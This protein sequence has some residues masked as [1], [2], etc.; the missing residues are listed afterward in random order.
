MKVYISGK[1]G[2]AKPSAATLEKFA[3]AEEQLRSKGFRVFNPTKSGLGSYAESLSKTNGT[4]FYTEIL[5]LDL[6]VLSKC[7]A[8]YML[9]DWRDSAGAAV[10]LHFAEAIGMT[11]LEDVIEPAADATGTVAE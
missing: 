5:L 11:V 10:E 1:I 9:P 7:D 8:I 3:K 4:G 6:R 2:E